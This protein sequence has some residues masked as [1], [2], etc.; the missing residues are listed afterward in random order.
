MKNKYITSKLL[1]QFKDEGFVKISN[2]LTAELLNKLRLFIDEVV[3]DENDSHKVTVQVDDKSYVTNLEL[4]CYK[5]N[6]ACLELLG[7]PFLLDIAQAI[8][9]EDFFCLQEFA[10]IKNLGDNLPVLWHQDMIHQR[11][12]NC[13]MVGVYLDDA[14]VNDGA[15]KV[16]PKSHL[17]NK[18]ICDVIKEEYVEI[19]MQAGDILIHDMML[20]H[21]SEPLQVNQKRRVI[22]LEFLS[23]T[24]VENEGIYSNELVINRAHLLPVALNYYKQQNPLLE[25][26]H[27]ERANLQNYETIE[28]MRVALDE[29]YAIPIQGK[30]SNYCFEL[31][32]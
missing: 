20:A 30:P 13:F 25:Q 11:T 18:N 10:V 27:W 31:P 26:F 4:L 24:Q 1:I 19:P 16:I 21:S 23:A 6:L 12:G 3:G 7:S 8:C 15:L 32:K 22:Y 2:C 14:N 5:K 29:I 17:S 9:G 28:E